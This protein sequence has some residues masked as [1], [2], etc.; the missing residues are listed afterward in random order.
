[1]NPRVK[2]V[3]PQQD[4]TLHL[5]FK[6]GEEGIFDVKPYLDKGIFRELK[7]LSMFNSVHPDGLSIEW[8]NEASLCPDT[9]YLE[10]VKI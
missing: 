2:D 4:Y 5:W 1:M 9:V 10:S 3:K 6:N 7:D 8:D